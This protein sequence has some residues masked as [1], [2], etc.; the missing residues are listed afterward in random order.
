MQTVDIDY[1]FNNIVAEMFSKYTNQVCDFVAYTQS[2][3]KLSNFVKNNNVYKNIISFAINTALK[4]NG[5]VFGSTVYNLPTIGLPIKQ[6]SKINDIDFIFRSQTDQ[7]KYLEEF[8]NLV[9]AYMNTINEEFKKNNDLKKCSLIASM[10]QSAY[11]MY[12]DDIISEYTD[13]KE[14]LDSSFH[15]EIE[16]KGR[17]VRRRRLVSI[18]SYAININEEELSKDEFIKFVLDKITIFGPTKAVY[19][20]KIHYMAD[21]IN[22]ISFD[23]SKYESKQKMLK[24]F[25]YKLSYKKTVSMIVHTKRTVYSRPA[26]LMTWKSIYNKSGIETIPLS[27]EDNAGAGKAP[28]WPGWLTKDY[29]DKF[30]PE[31]VYNAAS[32]I[33]ILC[34]PKSGLVCIDVDH[35]DRGVEVF[36]ALMKHFG[37]PNC[38]RQV[39]PNNGYH[40]IFKYDPIKMADMSAK[41]KG[42]IIDGKKIGIDFWLKDVQ[43]V[44]HPSINYVNGKQY[45]WAI[46]LPKKVSELPEM[47]EWIYDLYATGSVPL[48][49]ETLLKNPIIEEPMIDQVQETTPEPVSYITMALQWIGLA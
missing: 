34:G 35:K 23:A 20:G 46:P 45:T 29:S 48:K 11:Y 38:P 30:V 42:V 49:V 1:D 15:F 40:Y 5:L 37:I 17:F 10:Q 28:M 33:G 2:S 43:F 14:S 32:N 6:E 8:E 18:D 47:P 9:F 25:S 36:N 41:I 39:T 24:R 26:N 12:T 22:D 4:N 21:Q 19:D 16:N 7:K 27:C 31:N 44:A 3:N 13:D